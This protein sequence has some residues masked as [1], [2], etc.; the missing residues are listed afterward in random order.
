MIEGI[1]TGLSVGLLLTTINAMFVYLSIKTRPQLAL[2]IYAMGMLVKT[3]V[4]VASCVIVALLT[5]IDMLAFMLTLG[6]IV[7]ISY[8]TAAIFITRK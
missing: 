5:D 7:C 3:V 1:I 8:P 6:T 2:G 4:G